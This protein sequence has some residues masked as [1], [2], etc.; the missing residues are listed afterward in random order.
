M[1]GEA[2]GDVM[3]PATLS[4]MTGLGAAHRGHTY[5]HVLANGTL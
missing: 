2:V 1:S 4:N 5:L 3:L